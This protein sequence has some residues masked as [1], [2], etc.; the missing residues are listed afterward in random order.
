[1]EA[2]VSGFPR[3][4]PDGKKIVFHSRPRG[5]ASLYVISAEGGAAQRLGDG[6]DD[7]TE[8][9]WSH[10]GKWIYFT[11][12]RT[13]DK[14]VWKMPANGGPKIQVT[15]RGGW[16]PLESVDGR[17]LYYV[18]RPQGALWR[19]PLAG[20]E[21]SLVLPNVAGFGSAYAPGKEGIFFIGST[22]KGGGQELAFF[23]FATRQ[24]SSIVPIQRP[25]GLGLALSPDERLILYHQTDQ[26]GSV[27]ML[28]EN[29]R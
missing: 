18:K 2:V 3:W 27:L 6:D 23:R 11:S 29:F 15:K 12:R 24:I 1:M 22:P 13:G 26:I 16:S 8:P 7:E 28:V 20:G 9:S 19:L 4:S 21:E 10:D 14:Q 25:V 5:Y 17:Y